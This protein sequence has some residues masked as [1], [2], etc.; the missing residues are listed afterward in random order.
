MTF[1]SGILR[2]KNYKLI[3]EIYVG[4][5]AFIQVGFFNEQHLGFNS[6]S[7]LVRT[8]NQTIIMT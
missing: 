3:T 8:A 2:S 6:K 5:P 7:N 4:K 1:G